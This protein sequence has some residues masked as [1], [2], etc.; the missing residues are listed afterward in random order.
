METKIRHL[1]VDF[2]IKM[3]H[4]ERGWHGA[5]PYIDG[6]HYTT[7][8]KGYETEEMAA[9]MAIAGISST[10]ESNLYGSEM[11][12]GDCDYENNCTCDN[13]LY[14]EHGEPSEEELRSH[15]EYKI[16]IALKP[17]PIKKKREVNPI[18]I[19]RHL[20]YGKF[21]GRCAYCGNDLEF[22]DMQV[23][24]FVPKTKFD[25][26]GVDSIEN[27]MPSCK[28]CN[29]DKGN[30]LIDEWRGRLIN[31]VETVKSSKILASAIKFN[32]IDIKPFSG[33]FY[34]EIA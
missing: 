34:Y 32:M 15:K 14:F 16:Y 30:M 1:E 28:E 3:V 18:K 26:N 9:L 33:K 13:E 25:G 29:M 27:L 12:D 20:V 24:H 10:N 23:D 8:K 17:M 5:L 22:K 21:N 31:A 6:H 11:H 7:Y 2:K 19:D 4:D